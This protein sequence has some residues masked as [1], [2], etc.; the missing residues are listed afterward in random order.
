M[1]SSTSERRFPDRKISDTLLQFAAP[2]LDGIGPD[3]TLEQMEQSL[4]IAWTVWNAVVYTDVADRGGTLALLRSSVRRDPRMEAFVEPLIDRKRTLFGDDGRLIAEYTLFRKHGELRLRAEARDPLS[5]QSSTRR[6][7]KE[8]GGNSSARRAGSMPSRSR[9]AS[10]CGLCRL[11]PT[12][13]GRA[14]EVSATSPLAQRRDDLGSGGPN[15]GGDAR[16]ASGEGGDDQADGGQAE[17][18]REG[19]GDRFGSHG[20]AA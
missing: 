14:D 17:R 8:G 20:K 18:G 2:L 13:P 5:V 3:A 7:H 6:G 4:K 11:A 1:A 9:N 16:E 19:N 15:G 10:L 12:H